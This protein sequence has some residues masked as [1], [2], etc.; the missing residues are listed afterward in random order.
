M[1]KN[2]VCI[3]LLFIALMGFIGDSFAQTA[4]PKA[5]VTAIMSATNLTDAQKIEQV[6][7]LI[8]ATGAEGGDVAAVVEVALNLTPPESMDAMVSSVVTTVAMQNP[9]TAPQ[10]I[11][12]V[13]NLVDYRTASKIVATVSVLAPTLSVNSAAVTLAIQN[14]VTDETKVAS[15]TLAAADPSSAVNVKIVKATSSAIVA[16]IAPSPLTIQVSTPSIPVIPADSVGYGGQ[17]ES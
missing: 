6:S 9:A 1:T 7:A 8:I 5:Q 11:A 13:I 2:Y 17:T 4:S 10:V 16:G 3:T 14:T 15:V 12:S